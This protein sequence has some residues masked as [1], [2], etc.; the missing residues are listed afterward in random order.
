MR[1]RTQSAHLGIL[2]LFHLVE[3]FTHLAHEQRCVSLQALSRLMLYVLT[4]GRKP[5]HQVSPMDLADDSPDYKE[6]LDLVSSLVSHDERGVE[7]LSKHPYFWSK[8]T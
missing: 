1:P 6:A 3:S 5:L 7:G 4:K 2:V 8:Q